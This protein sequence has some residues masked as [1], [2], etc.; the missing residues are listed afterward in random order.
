VGVSKSDAS[1][2]N[3][4]CAGEP[5][6]DSEAE[7]PGTRPFKDSGDEAWSRDGMHWM[8]CST[9]SIKNESRVIG[10][11]GTIGAIAI[12]AAPGCRHESVTLIIS[13]HGNLRLLRSRRMSCWSR[14]SCQDAL[15]H[16]WNGIA[17]WRGETEHSGHANDRR[18]NAFGVFHCRRRDC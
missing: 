10:E 14:N 4:G 13:V 15:V 5:M 11:E 17:G 2:S 8:T 1:V 9:D 7:S 3:L 16:W 12:M 6:R 18:S